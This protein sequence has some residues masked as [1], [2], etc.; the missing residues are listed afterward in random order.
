[1][2]RNLIIF[3]DIGDTVI[4]EGTEVRKIPEGVV[5]Q[6]ECIPEAK[7]TMLTLYEKGYAIVMVADGLEES[8][9]NTMRI[10]GLDH[11]FSA[12]VISE[13]IGVEKPDRRMFETA[14]KSM[15]LTEADKSRIMMVGN[16][17]ER[18]VAGANRFGITSV[19][20]CW[21]PRY[22][23]EARCEEE[24]PDYRI[25]HPSELLALAERLE[26]KLEAEKKEK[27]IV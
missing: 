8:F 4:D 5:Y 16:N 12:W 20:L 23:A 19:H 21:S 3:T 25:Y 22:L 17:L 14:F 2:E 15:G 26:R 6:A 7:E 10:N 11:I 1:M 24:E 27:V 9:R 18:D 13:N